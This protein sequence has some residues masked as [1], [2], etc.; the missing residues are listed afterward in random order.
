M[1]R[2]DQEIMV[3]LVAELRKSV[4]RLTDFKKLLDA[5]ANFLNF[6]DIKR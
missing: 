3:R 2:F 5:L 6:K 4:S 1:P